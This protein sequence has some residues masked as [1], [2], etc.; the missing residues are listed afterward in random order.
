[1]SPTTSTEVAAELDQL[2]SEQSDYGQLRDLASALR[3]PDKDEARRWATV[4]LRSAFLGDEYTV[5]GKRGKRGSGWHWLS[6]ASETLIFLPILVTWF[7]LGWATLAYRDGLRDPKLVGVP[8]LQGW[9]T[10]FDGRLPAF[11]TFGYLAWYTVTIVVAL[12]GLVILNARHARHVEGTLRAGFRRRLA[13]ALT[14]ADLMLADLRLGMPERMAREIEAAADALGKTVTEIELAGMVAG[15]V[16]RQAA[17]TL[18]A[19]LPVIS[20][21]KEAATSVETAAR[22]LAGV[23]VQLGTEITQLGGELG[24]GIS[25]LGSSLDASVVRLGGQLSGEISRMATD[26]DGKVGQLATDL[27]GKVGQL[28][29]D[30]GGHLATMTTATSTAVTAQ[31]DGAVASTESSRRIADALGQGS[32]LVR[33]SLAEVS[34]TVAVYAHRTEVAADILGQAHQ[35]I[36]ELP[37]TVARVHDGITGLRGEIATLGAGLTGLERRLSGVSTPAEQLARLA[38][39]AEQL[40]GLTALGDQMAG[41]TAAVT[42]LATA[43]A[44]NGSGGAG[45]AEAGTP[46][47]AGELRAVSA[48]LRTVVAEFR[49]SLAGM[50]AASASSQ[51]PGQPLPNGSGHASAATGIRRFFRPK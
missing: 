19:A 35:A 6:V 51:G 49:A 8:F 23:Q 28:A 12:I 29:T 7:G 15:E 13:S 18:K 36:E 48:E 5:R 30:I 26:L 17:E 1:V 25:E 21:L 50:A 44:G 14:R 20:P 9:Q 34:G 47:A 3:R 31:R 43:P 22:S 40:S 4:D 24:A 37:K 45:R 33:D 41:L 16:Q 46:A 32:Q 11:L 39:I 27:D 38:A 42:R 10:G 2:A